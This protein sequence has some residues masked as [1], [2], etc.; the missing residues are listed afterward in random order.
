MI[1]GKPMIRRVYERA[2]LAKFLDD[3]IV[4]TDDERIFNAVKDFGGNAQ[5]TSP[6]AANG[7]ERIAEVA[8][9]LTCDLVVNIQGD[10]PIIDPDVIDQLIELMKENP[11]A[12]VGTLV[13]KI[14]AAE[15][16]QNPNIVKVVLDK[17]WY[18]LYFSRSV[19]PFQ[20]DGSEASSWVSKSS[21]FWHIGIYIYRRDFL[22]KFVRLPVSPL[23]K[24]E[25]L[26]QLRML[27]NGYRLKVALTDKISIGVDVPEDIS[28]VE[29]YLEEMN[30]E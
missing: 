18:A 22:L 15:D 19:I 1:A 2:Q 21:Y 23:E 10:E 7:T 20:R 9:N 17:N 26:E 13:R 25:Q 29:R 4:A 16:L 24:A 3:V 14:D 28:K 8:A 5:M 30:I 27:E 6:R 12:Q 11:Q